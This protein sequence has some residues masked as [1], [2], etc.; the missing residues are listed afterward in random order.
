MSGGGTN[1]YWVLSNPPGQP[2][3]A[4]RGIGTTAPSG[5]S[6][7]CPGHREGTWAPRGCRCDILKSL[8]PSPQRRWK[9]QSPGAALSGGY[10]VKCFLNERL[11]GEEGW[12]QCS[13]PQGYR[14]RRLPA[15]RARWKPGKG[16]G[17]RPG[18]AS[19]TSSHTCNG[20]T[21]GTAAGQCEK[22]G[23]LC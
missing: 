19:G 16:S 11:M 13:E 1:L 18:E 3:G 2:E 14:G 5:H 12:L 7:R 17:G 23:K 4:G 20:E 9:H 15:P 8:A 10:L 21:P 6:H 22:L